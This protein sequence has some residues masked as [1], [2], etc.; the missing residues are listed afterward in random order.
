LYF[1]VILAIR[2]RKMGWANRVASIGE[3]RSIQGFW[4]GNL[5]KRENL[6]GMGA[7][8]KTKIK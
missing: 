1:I 8:G 5:M 2:S 7:C 4:W 6:E 3:E